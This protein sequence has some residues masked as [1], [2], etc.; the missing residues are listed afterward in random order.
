MNWLLNRKGS[1]SETQVDAL[2]PFL[3]QLN[4]DWVFLGGDFSSTSMP[5]EFAKAKN[6]V[7]RLSQPWIA[8]PGNHDQYTYSSH[9]NRDYYRYFGDASAKFA[10]ERMQIHPIA[11]DWTVIALDTC[12]PTPPPSS[13]GIFTQ[14]LEEKLGNALQELPADQNVILFNHYPF[15]QND[16]HHRTLERGE[17]L[18]QLIRRHPRI[19]LYL[20]GHTHRN[21][22][23]DL[24]P[25]GL[26]LILDSGSVAQTKNGS[27]N[28]IDLNETG[29]HVTAYRYDKTWKPGRQERVVWKY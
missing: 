24:Q 23:A 11:P 2:F 9:R 26:P 13:R 6:F 16:E 22:I 10:Q 7:S 8:I 21:T 12:R 25:N 17:A 19:R 15:F 5:E 4:V 14:Q 28:L 18:E 1:F 20:H 27:W 3:D 29:A